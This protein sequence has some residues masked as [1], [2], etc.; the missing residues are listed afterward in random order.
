MTSDPQDPIS[1]GADQPDTGSAN[2]QPRASSVTLRDHD[3]RSDDAV[4][5]DRA[6]NSALAALNTAY[7]ILGVIMAGLIVLFLFSGFQSVGEGER[8]VRVRFGAIVDRDIGPGFAL[9]W[10]PP[11][12]DLQRI[13]VGQQQ[14]SIDDAFFPQLTDRQRG[15]T[16]ERI[17][18]SFRGTLNPA[19]DGSLITGDLNLAHARVQVAYQRT[20]PTDYLTNIDSRDE[21]RLLRLTVERAMLHSAAEATIDD[22]VKMTAGAEGSVS[23]RAEASAQRFLDMADQPDLSTGIEIVRLD[24]NDPS[25]PLSL[26]SEFGAVTRATAQAAEARDRAEQ[27]ARTSLNRLAGA[28]AEP[29]IDLIGRYERALDLERDGA[30]DELFDAINSVL[31]GEPATVSAEVDGVEGA[32]TLLVPAGLVSGRVTVDLGEA[33]SFANSARDSALADLVTFRAKLP[34]YRA[35]RSVLVYSEWARAFSDFLQKDTVQAMLVPAGTELIELLINRDPEIQ[36]E[37]ERAA[38]FEILQQGNEER[39][40]LIRDRETQLRDTQQIVE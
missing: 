5:M 12:G 35:N 32:E 15:Q 20:S 25:P 18:S 23:R 26:F 38:N 7:S 34:Q 21:Q 14:F 37:L 16:I 19:D 27:D 8:A 17:S 33:Q 10:P 2:T 31:L 3:E 9:A 29:L 30:A 39:E 13:E 28:A 40:N 36:R 24:V 22:I 4:L 11:I 6:N 1:S